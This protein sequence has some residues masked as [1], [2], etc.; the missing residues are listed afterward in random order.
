[1]QRL[2]AA[3]DNLKRQNALS[4]G[5]RGGAASQRGV[6]LKVNEINS[7]RMVLRIEQG[8]GSKDRYAMLSPRNG[9][10]PGS[11]LPEPRERCSTEVGYSRALTRSTP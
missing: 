6:G 1:M 5:L 10:A 7:Q 3:A 2:I 8:K 9:C 11:E 4:G